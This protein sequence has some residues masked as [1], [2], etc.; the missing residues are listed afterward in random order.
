ENVNDAIISCDQD[1]V[2]TSFNGVAEEIYGYSA[3]EVIGKR[4]QDVIGSDSSKDAVEDEISELERTGKSR[5]ELVQYRKDGSRVVID[6]RTAVLRNASGGISGYVITNR[7]VTD[8]KQREEEMARIAEELRR[9]NRELEQ[10]ALFSSHDLREPL[11]MM[12]SFSQL[13]KERYLGSLD[14]DA[15]EYLGYIVDGA[16]RMDALVN[17]LL[18][19]SRVGAGTIRFEATDMN[20]VLA[21]VRRNLAVQI[22]GKNV[23]IESSRLPVVMADHYQ[24][25]QLLSHLVSNAILFQ[26]SGTPKISITSDREENGWSISVKDNGIGIQKEYHEKIFEIF[27]RLHTRD[28]Y[29]GSGIGLAIC[30]RIVERHG[31]RIRVDSEPG[32]GSIFSFTIPDREGSVS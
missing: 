7:D 31:G 25:V 23:K 10:F 5:A 24:M 6:R 30:A 8:R 21:K 16:T 13:L 1:F 22:A 32:T 11:R 19:Y 17:D 29:P 3:A 18:D 27:Q 26:D 9:S 12:T 14:R 28:A 2:V 20:A 15:D 4:L